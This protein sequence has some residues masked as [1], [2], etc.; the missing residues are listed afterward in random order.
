MIANKL[1]TNQTIT[2]HF[3]N[4]FLCNHS[5]MC[6]GNQQLYPH[7]LLNFDMEYLSIHPPLKGKPM[8]L[9]D[10]EDSFAC[11]DFVNNLDTAPLKNFFTNA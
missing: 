5:N 7:M 2:N 3:H 4:S 6:I 11:Y 1:I 9:K 10:V 8:H